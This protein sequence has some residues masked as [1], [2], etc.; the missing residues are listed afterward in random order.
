MSVAGCYTDFHIDLGGTS[1]WY[2][3]L[4]GKK[5]FWLLPPKQENLDMFEQWSRSGEQE[6]TFLAD[7]TKDCQ[8]V[9]IEAGNTFFIPSG[10]LFSLKLILNDLLYYLHVLHI[11]THRKPI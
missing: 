1:V 7:E 6:K 8:L 4:K 9:T 10:L 2:H 11:F 3:V 5:S